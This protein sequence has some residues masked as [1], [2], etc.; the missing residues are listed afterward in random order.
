MIYDPTARARALRQRIFEMMSSEEIE[1][2]ARLNPLESPL[3]I[4]PPENTGDDVS[5]PSDQ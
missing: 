3:I 1:E 4:E 5:A 2:Y